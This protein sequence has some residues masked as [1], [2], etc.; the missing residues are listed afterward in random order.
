MKTK[1][2]ITQ[3]LAGTLQKVVVPKGT[4]VTLADNLPQIPGN[5]RYW[6]NEF[7]GASK[8]EIAYITG[9][10]CLVCQSDVE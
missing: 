10:G 2:E 8:A 1:R 7:E 4:P 9:Y 5:L 3:R 6:V